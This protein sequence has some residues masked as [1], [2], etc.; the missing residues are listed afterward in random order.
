MKTLKY[1][2]ISSAKQ[3]DTYCAALEELVFMPGK[4][5]KAI[6]DEIDLLTLLIRK[7]DDEHSSFHQL[8]PVELIRSLMD[9]HG[10]KAKDLAELLDISK[11]HVSEI[12]HYKKGLSKSIIRKLAARFKLSQDVFNRPYELVSESNKGHKHEKMMNTPKRLQ[13][14]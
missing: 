2:I 3:Y 12:L 14:A 13:Y 10:M 8:D 9:D 1:K 5:S 6:Q 7:W 11:S 4:K